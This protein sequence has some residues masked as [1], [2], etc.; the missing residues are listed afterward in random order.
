MWTDESSIRIFGNLSDCKVL[1]RAGERLKKKCVMRTV[2]Y[3]GGGCMIWA[4]F[5]YNGVGKLHILDR[6]MDTQYYVEILKA[7]VGPS[8]KKMGIR[9]YFFQQDNDPKH[10][11]KLAQ[12]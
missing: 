9:N 1:R 10:R 7:N 12:D 3:G 4:A 11:S 2:K 8:K 5:G 6:I